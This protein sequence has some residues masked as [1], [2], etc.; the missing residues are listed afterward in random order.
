MTTSNRQTFSTPTTDVINEHVSIR[1]YR[2]E[3]IPDAMLREI[4]NTARRSPTSSNMQAYS[5]VVVRNPET[6]KK[7]AVLAGNQ[8]HIET[9][10]TFVACCAD[11]SRLETACEMHG[12]S[13][14]KNLENTLVATVD[15]AIAG[16][17]LE[18]AAESFGLGAVMIGGMRN[19][20]DKAAELLGFPPGVFI[21]YGMCLGWPDED[22]RPHQKPRLPE[23]TII[24]YEQYDTSDSRDLLQAHDSDLAAHYEAQ[25][26][27][28]DKAAW[29]G[30]MANKFSTPRRPD[31]RATLEK[32]GFSFD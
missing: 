23:E 18:I 22:Q 4:L 12:T 13:L 21:V 16:M 24:H 2:D 9:C 7:L 11:V 14:A 17:T 5:F 8:R 29:T 28:L 19:H 31:L 25:G 32:M 1:R 26:R 15:A 30:V 10:D 6:K 27:N 20:P 3:P